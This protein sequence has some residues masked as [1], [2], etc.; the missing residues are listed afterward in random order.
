MPL[1]SL[2][3]NHLPANELFK[4][5][6]IQ[7]KPTYIKS[8]INFPKHAHHK[9]QHPD[10]IKI[11]HFFTLID[12][13]VIVLGI[14]VF[15]YLLVYEEKDTVDQYVFVSKCDTTGLKKLE[16]YRVGDVVESVL[17]YIVNYDVGRYKVKL[18]RR[19]QEQE[20]QQE[21][22]SSMGEHGGLNGRQQENGSA[23]FINETTARIHKLQTKL[24]ADP[25]YLNTLPYYGIHNHK[26]THHFIKPTK[27]EQL[28]TLPRRI[29]THICLFTKTAPQYMFPNS[30][31]NKYKHLG[32]GQVLLSWWLKIIESVCVG[33]DS[34]TWQIKRLLIPGSDEFAMRKF[35]A[36]LPNWSIG[37]IFS[38]DHSDNQTKYIS[39]SITHNSEADGT[40]ANEEKSERD[41]DA[42]KVSKLA[43]YNIPLFPDDP[44]GRFLEHLIVEN[45][46]SNVSVDRFYQELG[47]R[48]EFRLGDCVGLIGCTRFASDDILE[49]GER[50]VDKDDDVVV[51]SIHEYKSFINNIIKSINFDK[52]VDVEY[53]TQVQIPTFF[54]ERLGMDEFQYGE[55]VGVM[56]KK[57]KKELVKGGAKEGIEKEK[58]GQGSAR[59]ELRVSDGSGVKRVANDLTGLIKRKKR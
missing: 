31:G 32:N 33:N 45:R 25:T 17:S 34:G 55:V 7:S 23:S 19:K 54:K 15:V 38:G 37:H 5:I 57:T 53:L 1:K 22:G 21:E 44:K 50:S 46:Y 39:K 3:A 35:I 40:V 2:L 11:R 51:V 42:S 9:N 36:T 24:L 52:L 26:N 56:E 48:Q 16:G 4:Y 43:V 28:R 30:S 29:N 10:T 27:S 8:P 49:D 18:R 6:Y 58:S 59:S 12:G 47:F 41:A 20:Q 13:D 14:E